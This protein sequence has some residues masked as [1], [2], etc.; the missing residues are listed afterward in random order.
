[1]ALTGPSA[2]SFTTETAPDT[3]APTIVS[4]APANNAMNVA[5]DTRISVTFSEAMDEGSVSIATVPDVALGTATFNAQ[6][7]QVS[8]TPPAP[9]ATST[10]YTVTVKG[11]DPAKNALAGTTQF[12]FTTARPP[13]TTPPT[14]VSVTPV[15]NATNVAN[16]T[17]ITVTFSEAM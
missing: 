4:T 5:V 1:N 14:V 6:K 8:Y 15:N 3:T 16:N 2:F 7:T 17:S 9:F 13:D 12:K 10:E 11:Q